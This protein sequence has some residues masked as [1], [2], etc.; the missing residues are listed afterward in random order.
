[1][2]T[3]IQESFQFIIYGEPASKANSRKIVNFGK[4]MAIIKSAKARN[5]EKALGSKLQLIS[6]REL[7][8]NGNSRSV[9]LMGRY[10]IVK[11]IAKANPKA[12]PVEED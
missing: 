2:S 1:M 5:Y 11:E 3:E 8:G 9:T 6:V 7:F 4:R 12:A 10:K